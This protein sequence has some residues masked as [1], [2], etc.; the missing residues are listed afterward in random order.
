MHLT[1]KDSERALDVKPGLHNLK[2]HNVAWYNLTTGVSDA[3]KGIAQT[4]LDTPLFATS[5]SYQNKSIVPA[6]IIYRA[7]VALS[8]NQVIRGSASSQGMVALSRGFVNKQV[9]LI[10]NVFANETIGHQIDGGQREM[11]REH[12]TPA[13][14]ELQTVPRMILNIVDSAMAA[15]DEER[16]GMSNAKA[17]R[18]ALM[19]YTGIAAGRKGRLTM[20]LLP[21]DRIVDTLALSQ[22]NGF[23]ID[24][25]GPNSQTGMPFYKELA[26]GA[27]DVLTVG[28]PAPYDF[29][30][31]QDPFRLGVGTA[32]LNDEL[33]QAP[34][35]GPHMRWQRGEAAP[36]HQW[37]EM[38][39][40]VTRASFYQL[41]TERLFTDTSANSE[42]NLI[43]QAYS[44]YLGA[45]SVTNPQVGNMI[46]LTRKHLLDVVTQTA[47]D[48]ANYAFASQPMQVA[49][50]IRASA[51]VNAQPPS[52]DKAVNE[53]RAKLLVT[54]MV[55]GIKGF[56][57]TK[58]AD[59]R[60]LISGATAT[61]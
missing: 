53:H 23:L 28:N 1:H 3:A 8:A 25:W 11:L 34:F 57:T 48:V 49:D 4:G 31:L 16:K 39:R 33:D 22:L 50:L 45:S 35:W 10:H 27:V 40:S 60:S 15:K 20:S 54:N 9:N 46:D 55:A 52:S 32:L 56:A 42:A 38:W 7:S 58:Q 59:T 17:R 13:G 18:K 29:N 24:L 21:S 30:Q 43:L 47:T 12:L 26:Q 41:I 14:Q 2:D 19:I 61:I 5:E 37:A 44:H 36:E 6:A 51:S